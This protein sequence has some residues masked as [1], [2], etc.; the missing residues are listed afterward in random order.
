MPDYTPEE[1]VKR[2]HRECV[3]LLGFDSFADYLSIPRSILKE[4]FS[5]PEVYKTHVERIFRALYVEPNSIE[6]KRCTNGKPISILRTCLGLGCNKKFK[7]SV[8]HYFCESCRKS[9]LKRSISESEL[10]G[11]Q[12]SDEFS[13]IRGS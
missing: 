11:A 12:L 2:I 10:N 1:M 13:E 5:K 3:P 6:L 8:N 7:T 9:D 4:I